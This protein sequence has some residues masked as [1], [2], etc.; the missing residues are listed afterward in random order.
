MARSYQIM[1]RVS[2]DRFAATWAHSLRSLRPGG[3][4]VVA[5]AGTGGDPPAGLLRLAIREFTVM[6]SMLG[7]L[8]EFGALCRFMAEHRLYPPVS[9]VFHGVAAVP[10]ALRALATGTQLGKIVVTVAP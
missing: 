3:R 5:G 10:D 8:D 2:S 4:I 7:S 1:A 9:E 6:G